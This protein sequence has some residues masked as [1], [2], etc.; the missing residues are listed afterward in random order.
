MAARGSLRRGGDQSVEL[1]RLSAPCPM[2]G[3][4]SQRVH[5]WY[6]RTLAE[7]PWA[8]IPA[9]IR[10]WSRRFFCDTPDC[11]RRMYGRANFDLLRARILY[12]AR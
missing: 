6:R 4:P 11:P 12:A 10:L 7:L 8:G 5:S 2:C 9:R 1:T 3:R